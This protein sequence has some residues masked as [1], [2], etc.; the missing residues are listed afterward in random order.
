MKYITQARSFINKAELEFAKANGDDTKVRQAAEKA[1]LACVYAT[2]ALF[3]KKGIKPPK[4][5]RKREEIL[6]EL[7]K[8]DKKINEMGIFDK[9]RRFL[10]GLHIDCFYEGTYSV[11]IVERDIRRVDE[12]IDIIE[13]I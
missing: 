13:K 3:M 7:E 5:T 9:Y 8:K 1:W 6:S 10:Y 2:N 11:K 12:Y 4:G